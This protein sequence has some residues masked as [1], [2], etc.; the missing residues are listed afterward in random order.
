MGEPSSRDRFLEAADD[1]FIAKG[2][3]GCTIRAIAAQAGTSLASLSRNWT[4]KRHL[5][6][7]VFKRHFDPIH[8]AQHAGFDR[9][10]ALER[11]PVQEIIR[12]FFGSALSRGG[13]TGPERKS[14]LVY[15]C[16]LTD[17]SEEARSIARPLVAPVRSRLI[18]L[19]RRSRPD[20]DDQTFFFAMT[21]VLGA[22]L[23]P[24]AHGERLAGIMGLD[25]RSID[26]DRASEILSSLL[27]AGLASGK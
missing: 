18:N 3:D 12:V 17:P 20:L 15:C 24:Q 23:Y 10:D 5:F 22:Y 25:T 21:I 16:A 27:S 7:E 9:L 19:L 14:H 4:S 1:Q 26:W 2:Y 13:L 11:P 8:A 6:E